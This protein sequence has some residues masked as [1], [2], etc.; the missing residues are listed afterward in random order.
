MG[1]IIVP[2]I[3]RDGFALTVEHRGGVRLKLSGNADLEMLPVLGPFLLQLH[4]QVIHEG[5]RQVT[6]DLRELY[7]MNSSCFKALIMWIASVSKLDSRAMYTVQFVSNPK[8]HWQRRNLDA[9]Q[10]FAPSLVEV[11]TA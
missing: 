1:E 4:D 9:M 8:L 3:V 10:A 5:E 11:V 6:V 2:A 7:F